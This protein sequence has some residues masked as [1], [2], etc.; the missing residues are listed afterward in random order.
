MVN[1]SRILF[2]GGSGLLG[3][4]LKKLYP[5]AQFPT[6]SE[7]DVS[8][9]E[10]LAAYASEHPF[11]TFVHAAAF[12]SPPRIDENPVR[13]IESNI[14]GTANVVRLCA[15]LDAR[16]IYL[17]TDYVFRGD[18]GNYKEDDAV[19]PVNKYAWSKLGGECAVRLYDKGLTIRTTF[20][21][22]EF[23]YPKAFTDQWTSRLGVTALAEKLVPLI[24]GEMAGT[25]HVGGE[26]RT[27]LQFA[28]S[29]DETKDI[30]RLSTGDVGFSV[31]KDTSLDCSK[32]DEL[33]GRTGPKI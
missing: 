10:Q 12:T 22:D 23:P 32:Y 27:V 15:E 7:L 2:S 8:N 14:I 26:R 9:A 13:A 29:L 18:Q 6:S 11:E 1:Q 24:D 31:P 25:I 28:K 30:G 33:A 4:A 17:C 3:G 5:E 19:F 21:P 16:L 20:G